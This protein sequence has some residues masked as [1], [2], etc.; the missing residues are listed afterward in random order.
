MP[1]GSM[2]SQGFGGWQPVTN[3]DQIT[4]PR[5]TITK[6]GVGSFT[7][8]AADGTKLRVSVWKLVRTYLWH[9]L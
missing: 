4:L 1:D 5:G 8:E 2:M 6:L 7:Y 9:R 3:P